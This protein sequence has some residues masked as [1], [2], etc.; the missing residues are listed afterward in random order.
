MTS[1][2]W[3][4]VPF[5]SLKIITPS[6]ANV[7]T[8]ESYWWTICF[9]RRKERRAFLP[10]LRQIGISNSKCQEMS[11][12]C[13]THIALPT[14]LSCTTVN[15]RLFLCCFRAPNGIAHSLSALIFP[16]KF[17]MFGVPSAALHFLCVCFR[18]WWTKWAREPIRP[19]FVR[20]LI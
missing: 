10:F 8:K 3:T 5:T 20:F 7:T 15:I 9:N 17:W 19:T 16:S 6:T 4:D 1:C 14:L 11:R 18:F 2:V 12:C 13:A